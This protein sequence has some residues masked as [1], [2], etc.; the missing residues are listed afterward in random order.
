VCACVYVCAR[1][2]VHVCACVCVCARARAC[3]CLV[4]F[5]RVHISMFVEGSF[6]CVYWFLGVCDD[7]FSV[8]T[9]RLCLCMRSIAV[10]VLYVAV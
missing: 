9:A 7:L 5:L 4:I 2:R 10:C 3:F 8:Y 1:A 6:D